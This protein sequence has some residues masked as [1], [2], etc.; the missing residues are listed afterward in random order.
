MITDSLVEDIKTEEGFIGVVYK[1][2][3]GF[4]TIG[5]GTKLPLSKDEA[6]LI[7]R[8]RLKAVATEIDV[9]YSHLNIDS[10]AWD[11]LYQMAYQLGR[12]NL[13]KFVK[14]F[15]ALEQ[16]DYLM[17]GVEMRNSR[18]YKQTTNRAERLAIRMENI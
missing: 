5:Y 6:E 17:A 2:T 3:E 14:M 13:S 9:Y 4:D 16:Q 1:C 7:L 11:I 10:E 8:S 15:E 18:W 12:P